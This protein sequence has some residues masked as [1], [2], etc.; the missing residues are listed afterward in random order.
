MVPDNVKKDVTARSPSHVLEESLSSLLSIDVGKGN[1]NMDKIQVSNQ[2]RNYL[3]SKTNQLLNQTSKYEAPVADISSGRFSP[4]AP[5]IHS[6]SVEVKEEDDDNDNNNNGEEDDEEHEELLLEE[7]GNGDDN[8]LAKEK[9]DSDHHISFT[10]QK[11]KK[12]KKVKLKMS[13]R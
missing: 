8:K 4:W 2:N 12:S 9:G 1:T 13:S 10:K 5:P 3:A 7:G 6:M 11:K